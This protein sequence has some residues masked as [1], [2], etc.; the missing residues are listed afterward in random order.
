MSGV[1]AG[2]FRATQPSVFS[3][4]LLF[5]TGREKRRERRGKEK[6]REASARLWENQNILIHKSSNLQTARGR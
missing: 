3:P 6:D 1:T 5:L 4:D 2:C